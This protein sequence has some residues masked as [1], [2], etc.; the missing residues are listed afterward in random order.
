M[1]SELFF[2]YFTKN[3]VQE[4]KI[5]MQHRYL[6]FILFVFIGFNLSGQT[7]NYSSLYMFDQMYYNPGY[8]GDGNEIE[9]KVLV[10]NQWL[11]FPGAPNTQTFNIDGPF[12][13]FHQQHGAGISIITEKYG[14]FSNA[15]LNISYAYRRSLIQGDLGIGIGLYMMNQTIENEWIQNEPNDPSIP[16]V[17]ATI[18]LIFDLNLGLFYRADNLYMSVSTM[19]TLSSRVK[20][21][22]STS[23]GNLSSNDGSFIGRSVFF[24]TGYDYQLANPMFSIQPGAFI[25]TD[26]ASTQLSISGII[27]YN[28]RIF[29]GFTYKTTDAVTIMAGIDLPSGI[30]IA[31]S[32]DL[33]TSRVIRSSAGSFEFMAG[34]SFS[35]DLDK[36]N[37]K[38]KSVRFL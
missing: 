31:V 1:L 29:G 17:G 4:P 7:A 8:A 26:F 13:L 38:F 14:N 21:L 34:Y 32:Y 20:Y 5:Q 22:N 19:N 15:G 33:N 3:R 10:R 36:D 12:K 24:S 27:T 11:G 30:N 35:L 9:A 23:V 6:I 37:R 16:D 2:I 28:Q 18:P 25:A